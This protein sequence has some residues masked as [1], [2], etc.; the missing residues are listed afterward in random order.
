MVGLIATELTTARSAITAFIRDEIIA[1]VD[2]RREAAVSEDIGTLALGFQTGTFD[3]DLLVR[4]LGGRPPSSKGVASHN[5]GSWGKM[6][7]LSPPLSSC[8]Y[9]SRLHSY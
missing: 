8:R 1:I 6:D 5:Q 4:L 9:I 2:P 7:E 3:V